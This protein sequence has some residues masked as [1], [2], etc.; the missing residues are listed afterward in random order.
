M[1]VQV[2]PPTIVTVLTA[3]VQTPVVFEKKLTARPEVAVAEIANGA[4]P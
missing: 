2:P 4:T 1:I 3:T